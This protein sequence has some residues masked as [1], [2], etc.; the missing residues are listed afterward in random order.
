MKSA[1][2][3]P[4]APRL[5]SSR[6]W[7]GPLV[8]VAVWFL[9]ELADVAIIWGICQQGMQGSGAAQHVGLRTLLGLLTVLSL[10]FA[11]AAGA[12]SYRSWH[13]TRDQP[14]F[15]RTEAHGRWEFI[16]FVGVLVSGTLGAGI[17]LFILPILVLGGCWGMN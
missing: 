2:A 9:I 3:I 12:T 4:A 7:F 1:S 6:L 11:V 15:T 10:A 13:L 8:A 14:D 16:S 17:V 5:S